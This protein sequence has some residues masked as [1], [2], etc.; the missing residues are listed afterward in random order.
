[1]KELSIKHKGLE[2]LKAFISLKKSIYS[3][4]FLVTIIGSVQSLSGTKTYGTD[5]IEYNKYNN[6]TIFKE[7]FNH[8]KNQQDLYV[9]YPQEHWDLYKYTPTFSVLFAGFTLLPD[10]LGLLVWNLLNA[11][12]LVLAIFYLPKSKL[13]NYQKGLVVLI[14]LIELITSIQNEQSNGLMAGLFVF[15]LGLLEKRKYFMAAFCIVLASYIKLFGVVGFALFLFYPDKIKLAIYTLVW[16]GILF[17]LPLLYIDMTQYVALFDSYKLML[18]SDH[19]A[20]LGYSVMG[21]LSTWF[22]VNVNKNSIVLIGVVIFMLPF[23]RFKLYSDFKMRLLLLSSI[24][25]WVVIFNHKAES[26]TFVIAMTGVGIWFISAIKNPL[27]IIL[28]GLVLLFTCLPQIDVFP[29]SFRND[30]IN[31]YVLKAV[32]C[33]LVWVKIIYDMMVLKP[34]A[35]IEVPEE[36]TLE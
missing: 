16:T 27:N 36:K 7:S 1:M 28:F 6:Y 30:F 8:L 10:W 9:L 15:A 18:N 33:I 25:I 12:V 24:L 22:H 29:R 4:V 20:S 14:L 2:K 3:I 11:F 26:P 19:S 35:T 13:S 21:W 23:L 34:S 31:P 5:T 32:P 17:V